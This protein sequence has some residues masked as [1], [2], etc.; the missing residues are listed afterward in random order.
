MRRT[1]TTSP[2]SQTVG[3]STLC[4]YWGIIICIS[5]IGLLLSFLLCFYAILDEWKDGWQCLY[6]Y[7]IFLSYVLDEALFVLGCYCYYLLLS[8]CPYD[9][10]YQSINHNHAILPIALSTFYLFTMY[11]L[12]ILILWAHT[13]TQLV[14]INSKK[15]WNRMNSQLFD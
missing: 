2:L 12:F 10:I 4:C 7:I 5:R 15:E 13:H 6:I 14:K 3:P 11:L 9:A 1:T 8:S